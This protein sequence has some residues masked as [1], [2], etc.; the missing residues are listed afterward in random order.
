[1]AGEYDHLKS[2]IKPAV[3]DYIQDYRKIA[4]KYELEPQ[5]ERIYLTRGG[6]PVGEFAHVPSDT[7]FPMK[8]DNNRCLAQKHFRDLSEWLEDSRKGFP[9][10]SFSGDDS[11]EERKE[12]YINILTT[13]AE[14]VMD[15]QYGLKYDQTSKLAIERT[16]PHAGFYPSDEAFEKAFEIEINQ[17]YKDICDW[18][19][20]VVLGSFSMDD[21]DFAIDYPKKSWE[22][23]EL[24]T[25]LESNISITEV[26]DSEK[27]GITTYI[28][29]KNTRFSNDDNPTSRDQRHKLGF[30][31]SV[32]D[33]QRE[34]T[35]QFRADASA[36]DV[37]EEIAENVA[38]G[39]RLFKPVESL[40]IS[41]IYLIGRNWHSETIE[42]DKV[43]KGRLV[44]LRPRP[45]IFNNTYIHSQEFDIFERFWKE[46]MV[47]I[48]DEQH[49]I[50]KGLNRFNRSYQE[51]NGED[52]IIDFFIGFESTA[53]R[54]ID[55]NYRLEFPLRLM[56]LLR[57]SSYYTNEYLDEIADILQ[58][59]R[60]NVVHSDNKVASEIES[61]VDSGDLNHI[62]GGDEDY[63]AHKFQ[64]QIKQVYAETLIRYMETA[65]KYDESISSI[66]K[67]GLRP[68]IEEMLMN[69]VDFEKHL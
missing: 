60:N 40:Y 20:V 26:E 11:A 51:T 16:N 23:R 27:A 41:S 66:N 50:S 48:C 34:T 5:K 24:E 28:S 36:K 33:R 1:M 61:L 35:E 67:D 29:E 17:Q 44:S 3:F 7:W 64:H 45:S 54:D 68:A 18:K 9:L 39:L 69:P 65:E 25:T 52:A 31:L 8:L 46:N 58:D 32:E 12:A 57:D 53:L 37:S 6:S 62:K 13:F 21:T 38:T 43:D 4:E 56:L 14:S 47:L 30:E 42:V 55:A 22:R 2:R 63:H 19:V 10:P 15:Y 59:I 49:S